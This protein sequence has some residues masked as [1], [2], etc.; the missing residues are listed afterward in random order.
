MASPK[1]I[2][3]LPVVT[4]LA[5]SDVLVAN[6]SGI[7]SIISKSNLLSGI[8]ID[9]LIVHLA[10]TETITGAKT[11]N[12][13]SLLDK[14]EIVFDVRAYGALGTGAGTDSTAINAAIAAASAGQGGVVFFPAGD[15]IINAT[16]TVPSNVSLRGSGR[17]AT[18]LFKNG[19]TYPVITIAGTAGVN[20]E[21]I[22]IS[23]LSIEGNNQTGFGISAHYAQLI[24]VNNVSIDGLLDGAI[25]YMSVQDSYF[26]QFT[27]NTN[28]H[29][30]QPV[31]SIYGSP[32]WNSNMIWFSQCRI[33]DFWASAV[34]ITQGAGYTGGNNGF[35][36]NQFKAEST[37]VGADIM[38]FDSSVQELHLNQI[39]LSAGGFKAGYSTPV[40][41]IKSAA[42]QIA[43]YENIF[44]NGSPSIVRSV[45]DVASSAGAVIVD[46]IYLNVTPSVAQVN[47]TG[48]A[49]AAYTIGQ[50]SGNAPFLA[51]TIPQNY[52]PTN[53]TVNGKL[54]ATVVDI[55]GATTAGA[56][57]RVR[58]GVA[59]TTP[60]DGDIWYDGTDFNARVGA[61]SSKIVRDTATQTLTNKTLGQLIATNTASA[62][63]IGG[64][65][66]TSNGAFVQNTNGGN[67]GYFGIYNSPNGLIYGIG[68]T[69]PLPAGVSGLGGY[70]NGMGVGG[71]VSGT[72]A[73]IF[74]VLNSA[75]SGNGLGSTALTVYANNKVVTFNNTL[76]D[77]S[78]AASFTKLGIGILAPV[79]RL[80]VGG[81]TDSSQMFNSIWRG[82]ATNSKYGHILTTSGASAFTGD[83]ALFRVIATNGSDSG[84]VM[85]ITHNG[86]NLISAVVNINKYGTGVGNV[87]NIGNSGTGAALSIANSSTGYGALIAG[88]VGI[89]AT[90]TAPTAALDVAASTAATSSLRIR[91]G[92]AP[93]T[94]NDGD[95]WYD[96][97]HLKFRIGAT[98]LQLDASGG[99][100]YTPTTAGWVSVITN[101][102]RYIISGKLVTLMFFI[103]GT[104]NAVSAS[105]NLPVNAANNTNIF[106]GGLLEVTTDNGVS[107][108]VPGKCFI[109]PVGAPGTLVF[110]KDSTGANW[111]NA[112]TKTIRGTVVYESV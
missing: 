63:I 90:V 107:Q 44:M 56:S 32:A 100:N 67:S 64:A 39:F 68:G 40:N 37:Q 14:G 26:H 46:D 108:T 27:A 80:D 23:D 96:G 92:V 51:G 33:E 7:T 24:N 74:G 57:L 3:T 111:T 6:A 77:G 41:G 103:S 5:G 85:E 38:V 105:I 102:A 88:N 49:N 78:G 97:T 10:G 53:T 71:T 109:D 48:V 21:K 58:S 106:F 70:Y 69:L 59:P 31:I 29:A 45:L 17:R 112:G 73:P 30:T 95:A 11:F 91:S 86:T 52:L 75:Q 65:T 18:R 82:D 81:T 55:L 104:S 4:S 76:D 15:F 66:V 54:S 9:S 99:T 94:P 36:F 87:L 62:N 34:S 42:Y 47:F 83:G 79:A 20:V 8:P 2:S 13:K 93:T 28:H 101:Q 12:A 60:N 61:T 1:P 50:V 98:T 72:T 43:S 84:R 89:G 22:T 25:D 110:Y 19:A 35:F 16:L